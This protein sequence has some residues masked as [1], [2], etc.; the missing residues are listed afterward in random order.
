LT[1]D[2]SICTEYEKTVDSEICSEF[3][4]GM[5]HNADGSGCANRYGDYVINGTK[6]WITNATQADFIVVPTDTPGFS[7]AERLNKSSRAYEQNTH[8]LPYT[9]ESLATSHRGYIGGG[10]CVLYKS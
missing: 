6:M 2:I 3:H 10:F 4:V 8:Q 1:G 9:W 7:T 5:G